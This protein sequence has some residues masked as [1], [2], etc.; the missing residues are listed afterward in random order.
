MSRDSITWRDVLLAAMGTGE[1]EMQPIPPD[2]EPAAAG[3]KG[4]AI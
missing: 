4:R 3:P 1:V 2:S